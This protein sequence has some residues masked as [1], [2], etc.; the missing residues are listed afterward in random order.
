MPVAKLKNVAIL[1]LLLANLALAL[2]VV[3][4]RM[5][6]RKEE[7]AIRLSL[8]S[9]YEA[10]KITLS[11]EII[12]DTVPLYVL[13]LQKDEESDLQAATA[14]LGQQVLVQDD[15]TRY[16]S[17][18]RSAAGDCSISRNGEFSAHLTNGKKSRSPD[19]ASRQLLKD[20]GFDYRE[21]LVSQS[22]QEGGSTITAYQNVL[23]LPI[24]SKGVTFTWMNGQLLSLNGDFFTGTRSLSRGSDNRCIS[25]ADA[26]VSF[27]D[28]RYALG[29][30][31]SAV[32]NIQ[33]GYVRTESATASVVRLTPVWQLETDTGLF[34]VHGMT[35]DVTPVE[36]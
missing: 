26:L 7:D 29:W 35:G 36:N 1:I 6:V 31:G 28:A 34:Q 5:A 30:V 32:T 19:R 9:L 24:F 2:L 12:P 11:P 17:S 18:Y 4:G 21:P 20:M 13:E 27:L 10:Q 33:Q 22:L 25:A 8:C 3:P 23:D 16:L 14:L 15:S